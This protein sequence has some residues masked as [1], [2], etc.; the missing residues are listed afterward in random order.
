[1][2]KSIFKK[3]WF[4]VVAVIF[5]FLIVPI[6][7][8]ED[9]SNLPQYNIYSQEDLSFDGVIRYQYNVV[10]SEKVN[11]EQLKDIAQ[12]VVEDAKQENEFNALVVGF[13][14]YPEYVGY[15][16]TLGKVTYAPEGD[17]VKADTVTSGQYS[18]M[19]YDY[20]L[21]SKNWDKQLTADEIAIYSAWNILY[22][23][24][25]A[26]LVDSLELVDEDIVDQ[27]IAD[28]F[29]ITTEDVN[30]ILLKSVIWA[31]NNE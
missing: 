29:D 20:E 28:E 25:V 16:F 1:M 5:I 22:D 15:G 2:K 13:Y 12:E 14:D 9:Q 17:W 8:E 3:W 11:V 7:S 18:N 19:D 6:D 26:L 23:E 24:K 30:E 10:V 4:W 21:L 31:V 27:E